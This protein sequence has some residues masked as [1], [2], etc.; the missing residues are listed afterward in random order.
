MLL[1]ERKFTS[2]SFIIVSFI[3]FIIVADT[4]LNLLAITPI[5]CCVFPASVT[6][7]LPS[8]LFCRDES[9]LKRSNCPAM[10]RLFF[11]ESL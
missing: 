1:L 8:R 2:V 10:S 9:I 11:R 4:S 6:T 5:I 7:I 3:S